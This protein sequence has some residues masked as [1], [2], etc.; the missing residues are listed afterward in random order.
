MRRMEGK[1]AVVTGA[2]NGIGRASALRFAS[3]GANLAIL[4]REEAGLA[5]TAEKARAMGAEVLTIT[6]DCTDEDVVVD[7]FKRIYDEAGFIDVLMNNV[8]QSARER[9]SEFYQ[10]SSDVWRFVLDVSLVSTLLSSRQVVPAMREAGKG[11]IVNVASN[12]GLAGEVGISE[13]AAAKMG[14]IGFTRSLARELAPFK[15]NVN[16]V[17]PGVTKT[18]VLDQI[19]EEFLAKIRESI[20]LGFFAE[21]EDIAAAAAFLA[22]EDSRYMTGQSVVVDGGRWMV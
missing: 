20:P 21:P 19:S 17:C 15:V 8:G 16:A 4:D 11:K 7:A 9:A 13:Y 1:L 3:E 18:R 22:S 5:E 14:V 12:A 2:A 6:G 10:S